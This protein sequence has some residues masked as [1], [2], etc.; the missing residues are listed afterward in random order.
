MKQLLTTTTVLT[1]TTQ[2][3]CLECPRQWPVSNDVAELRIPV[4]YV[5]KHV[6]KMTGGRP[7]LALCYYR[8]VVGGFLYG[9]PR[10]EKKHIREVLVMKR[11]GERSNSL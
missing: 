2:D 5:V 4:T 3:P 6:V 11:K 9:I 7:S 8:E 10:E 1:I